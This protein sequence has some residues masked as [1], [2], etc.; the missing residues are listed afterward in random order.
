MASHNLHPRAMKAMKKRPFWAHAT[1][2]NSTCQ[3]CTRHFRQLSPCQTKLPQRRIHTTRGRFQDSYASSS[4]P[5]RHESAQTGARIDKAENHYDTLGVPT[6]AT[7][8]DIKK[9][10]YRLSKQHHPDTNREDPKAPKRFVKLTEAYAVLS[11]PEKR[12]AYDKTVATIRQD[13]QG[14]GKKGSYHG[15]TV[16]Y[17]GGRPA[18]GLS[19]R[20]GQFQGPPPSFFRHGG[21]GRHAEARQQEHEDSTK[22]WGGKWKG[23]KPHPASQGMPSPDQD[24]TAEFDASASFSA[25]AA[26]GGMGPGEDPFQFANRPHY[27][28]RHFDEK[29]HTETQQRVESTIREGVK[30]RAKARGKLREPRVINE[31]GI[32]D[33]A[34]VGGVVMIL[35]VAPILG[36]WFIG[37]FARD[38]SMK[39]E[40]KLL[41][42]Q[43]RERGFVGRE[44]KDQAVVAGDAG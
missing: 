30:A 18:T 15:S 37:S 3:A 32:A 20:R 4:E 6:H 13:V 19:K 42:R 12:S 23:N 41:E 16:R 8:S 33:F 35:V 44:A 22:T 1:R 31:V 21:W 29:R 9:S 26:A 2:A 25:G 27:G 14:Y 28:A 40:E 10:F 38:S 5:H 36:S 39:R 34:L 7:S 17:A 43:F 24:S 11:S